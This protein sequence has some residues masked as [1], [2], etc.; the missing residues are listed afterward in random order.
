MIDGG[1]I[2]LPGGFAYY[3]QRAEQPDKCI[4]SSIAA[5]PG[6]ILLVQFPLVGDDKRRHPPR[7]VRPG[8][9][10][11]MGKNA[12]IIRVTAREKGGDYAANY[13]G[14]ALDW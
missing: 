12:L 1:A 14:D 10:Q 4:Q 8:I 13:H 7:R 11:E 6:A 3:A 2:L 9:A 5:W